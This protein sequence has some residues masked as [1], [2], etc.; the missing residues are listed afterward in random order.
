MSRALQ[1]VNGVMQA[2][3]SFEEKK[4]VVS[5]NSDRVTSEQLCLALKQEGFAGTPI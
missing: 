5:L 2:V 1:A 3:V 4:A